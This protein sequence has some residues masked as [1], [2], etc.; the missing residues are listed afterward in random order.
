MTWHCHIRVTRS[1]QK[2]LL[3]RD[4]RDFSQVSELRTLTTHYHLSLPSP[5]HRRVNTR[6]PPFPPQPQPRD[7]YLVHRRE[8]WGIVR[9]RAWKG[10]T[11]RVKKGSRRVSSP[12]YVFFIL[13]FYYTNDYLRFDYKTAIAPTQQPQ[14]LETR[15]ISSPWYV[16]SITRRKMGTS[17]SGFKTRRTLGPNNSVHRCSGPWYVLFGPRYVFFYLFVFF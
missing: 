11:S 6:L 13:F 14:R 16:F 12:R 5:T 8:Q 9:D 2:S 3:R 17:A 7:A 15:Q 4:S 1:R 10:V